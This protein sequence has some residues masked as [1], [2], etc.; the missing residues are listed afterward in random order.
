M[1]KF[2]ERIA[3]ELAAASSAAVA[4]KVV[5]DSNDRVSIDA[6]GTITW[7]PGNA[8]ADTNLYRS[9]ANA[10][11]TDDSLQ[12][13]G[14]LVTV[15][16]AGAPSLTLADGGLAVDT[17][18]SKLYFRS[19]GTWQQVTGASGG[20]GGGGGVTASDTAPTSPTTGA[21]WLDS[22]TATLY[23]YYDSFWIEVGPA[24]PAG[25]R[26]PA[27]PSNAIFSA[28]GTLSTGTGTGRFYFPMNVSIMYVTASVGFSPVGGNVV[29]NLLLNGSTSIFSS[30]ATRPTISPTTFYTQ[31][32]PATTSISAGSY[33]TMNIDSVGATGTEGS[34]AVVQVWYQT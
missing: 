21:L 22:T 25:P 30:F 27:G 16:S 1:P 6:G 3:G 29:F 32:T 11:K 24:G 14:G 10:L 7:G 17:T 4:A 2:R 8:A 15:T 12:A 19:G 34:N 13:V 9:A 28:F 31:V 23:V 18:N 26:G 33:L 5:A 20:G